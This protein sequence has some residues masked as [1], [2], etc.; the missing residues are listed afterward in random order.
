MKE[1][2]PFVNNYYKKSEKNFPEN[3]IVVAYEIPQ[4]DISSFTLFTECF[5]NIATNYLR[6][7]YTNAYTPLVDMLGNYFVIYEQGLYKEVDQMEDDINSVLSD[8]IN[9]KIDIENF[10]EIY[11]SYTQEF[12]RK[13]EKTLDNLFNKFI[14][15]D[16]KLRKNSEDTL[17]D[18]ELNF[19]K[20]VKRI[21]PNFIN[22]KRTTFLIARNDLSDDDFDA[23]FQRRSQ[24]SKYSLN[25]N[26]TINH[27]KL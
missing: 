21:S 9:G 22:P 13:E 6:F 15:E 7:N 25:E 14:S 19:A 17:K 1:D 11:D 16:N 20:L 27:I 8:V 4:D 23:M 5:K 3:G 18:D 24:I 26:I 12:E 10:N 2:G